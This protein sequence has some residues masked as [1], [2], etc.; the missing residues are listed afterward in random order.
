MMI[1]RQSSSALGYLGMTAQEAAALIS[2]GAGPE[3]EAWKAYYGPGGYYQSSPSVQAAQG[4]SDP[5]FLS[6]PPETQPVPA[7]YA[8]EQ[9]GP[10]DAA[11]VERNAQRQQANMVLLENARNQYYQDVCRYNASLNPWQ[12]KTAED[13][14]SQFPLSPVPPA[15]GVTQIPIQAG[16]QVYA[17]VV[18]QTPQAPLQT[19]ESTAYNQSVPVSNA[20]GSG[21]P[22]SAATTSAAAGGY[23]THDY[24]QPLSAIPS[25]AWM[26]GGGVLLLLVLMRR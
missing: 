13:C 15:S 10:G 5:V 16:G 11:C 20:G 3:S 14:R 22:A 26:A 1:Y 9:C 24:R 7:L 23:G 2:A 18:G 8:M 6:A 12:G 19:Y 17:P 25:W 4:G 21:S